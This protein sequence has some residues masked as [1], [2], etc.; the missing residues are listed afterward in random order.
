MKYKCDKCGN[1]FSDYMQGRHDGKQEFAAELIMAVENMTPV[2][3]KYYRGK[4]S[5]SPIYREDVI[6]LIKK[7]VG[8]VHENP[9]LLNG[10]DNENN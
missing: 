6:E 5:V 7:I 10:G 8:N 2:P 9:E 4:E 1:D 3:G